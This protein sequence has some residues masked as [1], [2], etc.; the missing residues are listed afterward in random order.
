[1]EVESPE[2]NQTTE[3]RRNIPPEILSGDGDSDDARV[4]K[5]GDVHARNAGPTTR[6]GVVFVPVEESRGRAVL[7]D[8][9]L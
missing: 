2:I 8:G 7:I 1:M 6:I 5:P 9:R 3:L 4:R